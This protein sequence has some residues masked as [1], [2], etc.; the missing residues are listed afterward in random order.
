MLSKMM[1]IAFYAAFNQ[2]VE[3]SIP[4][5]LTNYFLIVGESL[6]DK[7]TLQQVVVIQNIRMS[8]NTKKLA[9]KRPSSSSH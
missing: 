8:F 7:Y 2:W 1:K 4:S 3:G 9:I 5:R 6:L